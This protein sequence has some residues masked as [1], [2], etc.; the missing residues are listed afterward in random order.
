M[1]SKVS[2]I[3]E[4]N[5]ISPRSGSKLSDDAG[6]MKDVFHVESS[7]GRDY[8]V[9]IYRQ[10]GGGERGRS[11]KQRIAAEKHIFSKIR[12]ETSLRAPEV[13]DSGENFLLC[14]WLSGDVI[15]SWEESEDSVN[16]SKKKEI[17]F[18]MG[19]ALSEI[20]N[21]SYDCFGEFGSEG[22]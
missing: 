19:E 12:N 10:P 16:E 13:I 5:G 8:G 3:L 21:I 6:R 20:H 18:K 15:G 9:Y 22:L 1:N 14:T 11:I 4:G 2:K 17:A 7:E